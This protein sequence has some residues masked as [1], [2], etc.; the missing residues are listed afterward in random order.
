ERVPEGKRPPRLA[1]LPDVLEL[2]PHEPLTDHS[3]RMHH[4][5]FTQGDGGGRTG[6]SRKDTADP[7]DPPTLKK[8]HAR[9]QFYRRRRLGACDG[10]QDGPHRTVASRK[11]PSGRA[12]TTR[13]PCSSV[14]NT[15]T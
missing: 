12:R 2:M 5:R 3:S 4:N 8:C 11:L 14:L 9:R 10:P 1:P 15:R 7:R 6:G 13:E